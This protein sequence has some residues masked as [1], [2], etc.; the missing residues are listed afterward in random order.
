MASL[1][2][3]FYCILDKK[4]DFNILTA[5]LGLVAQA[6]SACGGDEVGHSACFRRHKLRLSCPW[7]SFGGSKLLFGGSI[8]SFGGSKL[9]FGGSKRNDGPHLKVGKANDRADY[10]ASIRS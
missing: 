7:F 2:P 3:L 6:K 10:S 1:S 4:S 5:I 8:L 9:W